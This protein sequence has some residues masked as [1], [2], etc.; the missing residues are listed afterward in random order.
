MMLEDVGEEQPL[1]LLSHG[2]IFGG[3]EVCHLA[4]SI[5]HNHYGIKPL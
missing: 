1:R 5:H 4:K 2:F 3:N